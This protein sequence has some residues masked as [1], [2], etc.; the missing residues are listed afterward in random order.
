MKQ[1]ALV[2]LLITSVL[3]TVFAGTSVDTSKTVAAAPPCPSWY[4]DREWSVSL[5]GT[6]AFTGNDYP[7]LENYFPQA[8]RFSTHDTYLEAD[9]A[10]G[11]GVD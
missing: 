10:W 7:T 6:Y 9:H 5:W 1:T 2:L 4:A 3:S 8:P 11:G